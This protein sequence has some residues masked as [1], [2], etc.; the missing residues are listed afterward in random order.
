M[1]PWEFYPKWIIHFEN[2]DVVK[3]QPLMWRHIPKMMRDK[4]CS[5]AKVSLE[6]ENGLIEDVPLSPYYYFAYR[7]TQ[8]LSG[9][10]RAHAKVFGYGDDSSNLRAFVCDTTG[11]CEPEI[12]INAKIPFLLIN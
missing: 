1:K 12:I 10:T 3:E 7:V 8:S 2:G 4:K 6:W 9:A 5:I 11:F